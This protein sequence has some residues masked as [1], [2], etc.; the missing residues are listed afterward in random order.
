[1]KLPKFMKRFSSKE[2][3][4]Q[5]SQP[6]EQIVNKTAEEIWY[7]IRS[8]NY[9]WDN[10][11]KVVDYIENIIVWVLENDA[12]LLGLKHDIYKKELWL[13]LMLPWIISEE[14]FDRQ[15]AKHDPELEDIYQRNQVT[16]VSTDSLRRYY[17]LRAL[18]EILKIS[19]AEEFGNRNYK[20]WNVEIN[21]FE[22]LQHNRILLQNMREKFENYKIPGFKE[23]VQY[24]AQ[25]G[26][27]TNF[28]E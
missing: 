6:K 25:N 13:A 22:D 23:A 28:Y 3:E 8:R 20:I 1:M 2:Q 12:K 24:A 7:I 9:Q 11:N 15:M 26:I 14:Y 21:S 27:N 10:F 5:E 18:D 19:S 16:R 4:S 17:I